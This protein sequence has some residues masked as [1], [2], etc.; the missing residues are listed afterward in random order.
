[1]NGVAHCAHSRTSATA[2]SYPPQ[3]RRKPGLALFQAAGDTYERARAHNGLSA[4]LRAAG[5]TDLADQHRLR[6]RELYPE[7]LGDLL[8]L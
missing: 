1:V 4:A 3:A 6:A 5:D 2:R 7:P 8:P